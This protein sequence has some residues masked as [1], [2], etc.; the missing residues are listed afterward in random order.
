MNEVQLKDKR[1][2]I[3]LSEDS[4]LKAIDKVAIQLNKDL[5]DKQPVFVVVLNGAFMFASDLIGKF[6]SLCEVTFIRLKSYE[7][8]NRDGS[9]REIHGLVEDIKGRHVVIVEDIVDTGHT[10]AH[11]LDILKEKA[12][13]SI[14]VATL[15]FKPQALQLDVKPDYAAIEIPND[16]IVGYGLDYD[17]WGRN[18]RNIYKLKD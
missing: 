1:F 10:I 6:E 11:L 5:K 17:G 18:L 15:L 16:F 14:H 12:P 7:G 3:F 13:K 4:I 2:E 9:M 8:I